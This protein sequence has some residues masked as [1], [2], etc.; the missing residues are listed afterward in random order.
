M[1]APTQ[2]CGLLSGLIPKLDSLPTAERDTE[3]RTH[4]TTNAVRAV[5]S[6][7]STNTMKTDNAVYKV[8]H[9]TQLSQNAAGF[10]VLRRD[11]SRARGT[12]PEVCPD[13][14]IF[15]IPARY[16]QSIL[17]PIC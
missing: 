15:P 7:T 8:Q 5:R 9:S 6:M 3:L 16:R 11:V 17:M 2:R 12:G 10:A 4:I 14:Y 13:V 1:K